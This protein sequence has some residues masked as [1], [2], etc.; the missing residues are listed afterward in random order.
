MKKSELKSFIFEAICNFYQDKY[1]KALL[2]EDPDK[3]SNMVFKEG[4]G[5]VLPDSMDQ[6]LGKF[7]TLKHCLVRIMTDQYTEFVSGIDWISPRPTE[8]RI[9][10]KNGQ[11]FTLKWLGKDFEATISGKR[12]YLGQMVGYQQALGKLSELYQEG[13]MGQ[14]EEAPEGSSDSSSSY[15]GGGGGDFPGAESGPG[16]EEMPGEGPAEE[17]GEEKGAD[18]G[19]EDIDFEEPADS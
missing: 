15:G 1:R 5:A 7:P 11:N 17:G 10:L 4:D 13:P 16:S 6:M 3:D 2:K 12:Y 14:D 18:V 9:N 8:F 19:D